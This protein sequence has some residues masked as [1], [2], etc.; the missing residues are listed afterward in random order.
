MGYALEYTEAADDDMS[1]LDRRIAQTVRRRLLWL[2]D[3][4]EAINH[5][6]L[7]GQWSG[8]CRLQISD[9]RAIYYLEH[10]DRR[11]VVERVGH[12]SDVY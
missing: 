10:D 6:E 8:Y 3:N 1:R 9:Y 2:A 11:V 7:T 12:R 4:A 5:R